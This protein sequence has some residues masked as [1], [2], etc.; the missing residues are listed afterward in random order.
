[1]KVK[2]IIAATLFLAMVYA[3]YSVY[4]STTLTEA[5]KFM[6]ANV[7]ALTND[8]SGEGAGFEYPNA[9]P[10]TFKCNVKIGSGILG[11]KC[12]ATIVTC[13]GGGNGCNSRKC[14]VHN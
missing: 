3:G 9:F 14:P 5:E 6:K 4:E 1:M 8:E 7:E 10:L 12:S 11:G 2:F 13:Q